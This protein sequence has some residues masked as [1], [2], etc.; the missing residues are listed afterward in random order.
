[1]KST[2]YPQDDILEIRFSD[3]PIAREISQ[4]WN[5]NVSY[6]EDGTIVELVIL[7]AVKAGLMPFHGG[8]T[9]RAA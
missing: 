7:D 3:K 2:Y 1:M 9:R 4:D 8:E 5:V 6:A